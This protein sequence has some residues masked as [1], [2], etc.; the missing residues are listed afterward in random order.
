LVSTFAPIQCSAPAV[1]VSVA[2]GATQTLTWTGCTAPNA[3]TYSVSATVTW[4]DVNDP[5]TPRTAPAAGSV[6]V[7]P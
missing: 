4:V 6:V 5:A 1:P 2:G 7:G 3:R